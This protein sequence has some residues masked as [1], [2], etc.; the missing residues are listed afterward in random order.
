MSTDLIPQSAQI[1][2]ILVER[3]LTAI[4]NDEGK[5]NRGFSRLARMLYTVKMNESW[6]AGGLASFGSYIKVLE[7]KFGRKS[8]QLFQYVSV[9]EKLLPLVGEESLDRMGITKAIELVRQ[10]RKSSKP[11]PQQLLDTALDPTKTT[12][13]VRAMSCAVFE[14]NGVPVPEKQ[15][16]VDLGGFYVSDE[17]RKTF[18]D[19]I[20]LS[21]RQL[22]LPPD[23][24][25]GLR[26]K[27]VFLSW[28]QEIL[29]TYYPED[30]GLYEPAVHGG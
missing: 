13:D 29:G 12:R 11:I 10:S 21:E 6:R 16:F 4:I 5:L 28:A 2:L 1:P 19:A 14:L 22:E 26:R 17:E 24:P 9:A 8:Q 20:E 7:D 25:D 30:G 18:K 3:E 27:A 15:H 23:Y